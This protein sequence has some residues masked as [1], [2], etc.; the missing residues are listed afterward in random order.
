MNKFHN[1]L[2]KKLLKLTAALDNPLKV[3]YDNYR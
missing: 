3:E 2:H 1:F